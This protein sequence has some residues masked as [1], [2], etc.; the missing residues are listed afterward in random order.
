MDILEFAINM[1]LEGENYYI[2]QAELNKDNSLSTVLLML[3]KEEKMHAK[4]LQNK[5]AKLP[6]ELKQSEA[7]AEAKNIF[8]DV[9]AIQNSIKQIPDQ[10]DVYRVALENEEK[11]ITLYKKFSAEA[12]DSETKTLF[13]YLIKQEEDHYAIINQL[14]FLISHSEEWVESAEFGTREEY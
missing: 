5:A 3:A 10:L 13:E 6:Y 8:S 11:S 7:L 4:L 2:K 9:G 1:E 14:V 12:T